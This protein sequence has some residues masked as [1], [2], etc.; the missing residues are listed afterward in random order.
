MADLPRGVSLGKEMH[1]RMLLAGLLGLLMPLLSFAAPEPPPFRQVGVTDGLPS[2]G[3]TSLALDRDGYLWIGTRDG[4]ARYDG[5]GYTVFRHIP[6]DSNALPGN[7]VQTIFVDSS[8]RIW[9]GI[10]GQGL[11]VLGRDRHGFR[12]IS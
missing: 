12:Q 4:L 7:F 3:L 10:E 9:V 11:C 2:S 1:F 8:N 6:G 5:V